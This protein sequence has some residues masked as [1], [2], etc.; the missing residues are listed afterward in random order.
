MNKTNTMYQPLVSVKCPH[1][2]K[3]NRI[4]KINLR[5]RWMMCACGQNLST[6]LATALDANV[7]ANRA[8]MVTA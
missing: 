2:E 1:C 7:A 6:T 8:R 4:A 3:R 5:T